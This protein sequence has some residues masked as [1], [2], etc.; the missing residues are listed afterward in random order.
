MGGEQLHART[1][2]GLGPKSYSAKTGEVNENRTVGDWISPP[3]MERWPS[4][5]P[6]GISNSQAIAGSRIHE[7]FT[8][9]TEAVITFEG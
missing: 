6:Y 2:G 5:G 7:G 4:P 9:Q 8:V 3:Q 1:P